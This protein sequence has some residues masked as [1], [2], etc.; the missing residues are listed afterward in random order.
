MLYCISYL[1]G[2][3]TLVLC[4][5][6]FLAAGGF[7]SQSFSA[8]LEVAWPSVVFVPLGS[9]VVVWFFRRLGSSQR[10]FQRR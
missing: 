8:A 7:G 4:Y 10:L 2:F 6:I 3:I 5:V 9:L 1:V